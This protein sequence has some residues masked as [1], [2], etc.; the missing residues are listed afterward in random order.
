MAAA[1]AASVLAAG[2]QQRSADPLAAARAACSEPGEAEARI[3]ACTALL[4]SGEIG[5]SDRALAHA[6]RGEALAEAGDVTEALRDFGVAL[7]SDPQNMMAVKGRAAILIES[8][9]LD[10]A[11]PLVERLIASGESTA[12]ASYLNGRI[13]LA[14]GELDDA[15]TAFTR[16][17]DEDDRF[18]DAYARR[19]VAK[20]R[21]RDYAAALVDF[22][23]AIAIN[24]QLTSAL[25]GRCWARVL[26]DA[27]DLGQA[28]AD[29]REATEIDPR[30][31]DAQ[32][33]KGLL[34]LRDG[35]WAEARV[36]YEAA[37]E[38]E[39]GNPAAL[40]GRGVSR[41]RGG[42]DEGR[43]DMNRARDFDSRIA[44]TFEDLGVRTF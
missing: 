10:A 2:C 43:D 31:V 15:I 7:E 32:L 29:A 16:A 37:L 30:L 17:I 13:L 27:D 1:L 3:N 41:R 21:Q 39:P 9:Q 23:Q 26:M 14:R 38:V 42:D 44:R 20:Q 24:P 19:A 8:G 35:E 28:R 22:D 5:A 33:C 11:A 12:E 25:A 34:H 40:F 18:A 6:G 36:A 4:E